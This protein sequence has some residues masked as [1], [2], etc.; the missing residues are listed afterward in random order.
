MAFRLLAAATAWLA[1]AFPVA[2][3]AQPVPAGFHITNVLSQHALPTG[4]YFAHDGRVVVTERSGLV[5]IY[6]DLLDT[7][8]TLLADLTD[9]V[10]DHWDRGLLGFALHPDFPEVPYIYVQY[11]YNGG[12]F[13]D[14]DPVPWLPRWP[15]CPEGNPFC[16]V[17]GGT[18]FCPTPPGDTTSGGGCVISGRVSRLTV[19]G[20]TAGDELVLLED[21]YQQ[22]PSHSIGTI[23]FGPDGYLYA[24]GG[25]GASFNWHDFGQGGNAQ[26]PDQRSPLNA[27]NP[28]DQATNQGGSLRSQ[29]LEIQGQYVGTPGVP[30]S[31]D[32]WLNGSIVRID[33]ATGAGAPGNPLAD[34][35]KPNARRIVAYGLRNPFRFTFRPGAGDLWIGDVGESTW[36]EINRVPAI[37]EGAELHNF[38]W[39]CYEGRLHHAG[40]SGPICT[41]LYSGGDTGG[42]TPQSPPWYAYQH[43]GGSDITGLAFYT[44]SSYPAAYQGSL[45]FADNSRA[46]IFRIPYVDADEDGVPDAPLD[47]AAGIFASGNSAAPVQLTAG[48][49]GDLFLAQIN[50]GRI[51]RLW[52]CDGCTNQAP[53]AAIAL[54]AASIWAGPP[55]EVAFTA[56]NSIDPDDNVMSYAWDLDGDGDF[57]DGT[58]ETASAFFA[59]NGMHAVA[60]QAS[61][62]S[63]GVDVARMRVS[64]TNNAPV[65]TITSPSPA[66]AWSVGQVVALAATSSDAEQGTL[67]D[68]ALAW[69]VF[70][71]DCANPD[72]TDCTETLLGSFTGAA[73]QF[74]APEADFPAYL[75]IVLTGTDSGNLTASDEV[76]IYPATADLTLA[77]TPAGLALAFDGV[78]APAPHAHTVILNE[79]FEVAAPSP[80][81]LDG[82]EYAFADWSDG[83][84][85]THV[86]RLQAAGPATLEAA[87]AATA[88]IALTLDDG[89][90]LLAPGDT[91]TWTLRV[92]N[93]GTNH[94]SG[95]AVSAAFPATLQDVSWVCAAG[96]GSVCG[97]GGSGAPNDTAMLAPGSQVTYAIDATLA[98]AATGSVTVTA[99]AVVPAIY[100]NQS[101]LDDGDSDTDVVD[102]DPIFRD[103]FDPAN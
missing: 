2:L 50:L 71:Q 33:P 13:P 25:D 90:A 11:A 69:Q 77:S 40:F 59:A 12:L 92:E 6:D 70:R 82:V 37:G 96:T 68:A 5:W 79:A 20:D 102:G 60:V 15:G 67:P 44:G 51:G 14:S 74:T 39:P 16:G 21:W 19:Q 76:A 73:A 28:N 53:S 41:S 26:Y 23:A 57:D 103:G 100:A 38:G 54:D 22:F 97:S 34:D 95:I 89:L 27:I 61:D 80:Q 52:W 98:L 75:R 64:V 91:A 24:G 31:D 4:V 94:L 55:R 35:A 63:G 18:D 29:G 45:F 65:V 83:G 8:P 81:V 30:G 88:N 47:N 17:N 87:F 84:A 93:H 48:P 101:P 99:T 7:E 46:R 86:V 85:P 58:G 1:L 32:V 56:D 10:H 9:E 36:E 66:L 78:P 49:G 62:G 72:F 42:R 3:L 43:V